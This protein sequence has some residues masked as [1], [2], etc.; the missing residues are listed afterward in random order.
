MAIQVERARRLFTVDEYDRTVKLKVYARAG[1]PEYWIV[2]TE[3]EA[4]DV[5]REPTADGYRTVQ[6]AGRDRVVAPLGLADVAV[7]V[8]D[9]FA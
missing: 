9:V 1:I 3:A 8:N 4:I 7:P 2:D 6:R 5:Y